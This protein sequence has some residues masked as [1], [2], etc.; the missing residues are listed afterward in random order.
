MHKTKAEGKVNNLSVEKK[1]R[2]KVVLGVQKPAQAE[3]CP[4]KT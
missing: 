3:C 1:I 4:A 2:N